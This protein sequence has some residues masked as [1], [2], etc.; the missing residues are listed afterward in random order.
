MKAKNLMLGAAALGAVASQAGAVPAIEAGLSLDKPMVLGEK[1]AVKKSTK[2]I[3]TIPTKSKAKAFD[4]EEYATGLS[5][6][7]LAVKKT[8]KKVVAKHSLDIA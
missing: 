1:V 8:T 3:G 2:K 5:G 6:E 4:L 7:R